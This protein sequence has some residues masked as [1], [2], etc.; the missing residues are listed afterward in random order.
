MQCRN[1]EKA[2][3]TIPAGHYNLQQNRKGI[4]CDTTQ[5]QKHPGSQNLKAV[6]ECVIETLRLRNSYQSIETAFMSEKRKHKR[7]I[8]MSYL[9]IYDTGSEEEVGY[10]VDISQGGMLLIS[11][12]E[13]QTDQAFTYT[14]E[15]PSEIREEGAFTVTAMS[16]RCT[17][18]DFLDYYNTGFCFQDLS[19][20]DVKIINDIVAVLEL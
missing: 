3:V 9:D 5:D 4:I 13:I 7:A 10:V 1:R 11:K 19:D 15:I 17:K 16:I 6:S 20:D 2:L 8:L 18:D 14:I 12:D